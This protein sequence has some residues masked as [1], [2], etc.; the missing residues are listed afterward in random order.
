[1]ATSASIDVTGLADFSGAIR[2]AVSGD[3]QKALV[4][5]IQSSSPHVLNTMRAATSSR[6][7]RRAFRSVTSTHKTDGIELEGG[8]VGGLAATLFPGGEYGGR[9]TKK[10]FYPVSMVFG[11]RVLAVS[12]RATMMFKPH[13][14]T[15][16]YFFWPTVRDWNKRLA[17]EQDEIVGRALG[18]R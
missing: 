14:G 5:N 7:E 2:K 12:K 4:K 11:N 10:R 17:K 3:L 9:A 13:L 16:G 15:H 1:V 18:G 8:R 6:V